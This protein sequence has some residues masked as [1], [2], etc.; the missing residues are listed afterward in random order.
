M[1]LYDCAMAPNPRRLRIFMA[2]KGLELPRIELNILA[3]ENLTPAFLAINPR[4]LLPTLELDDGTCIDEVM[5]ICRYLEELYPWQPLLGRTATERALVESLQRRAEFDGM[6]SGSEVFRNQHP[7]FAERSIPG[8]G[9]QPIPAIPG[10]V[11]RGHQTIGR[12][13]GWL[14]ERLQRTPY[15]VG[16][17]LSMADI[18][19]WCAVDFHQ[20][21]ERGIPADHHATHAWHSALKARPSAAA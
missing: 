16:D 4:G 3:G 13:Y 8:S 1:R 20:W 2:E 14:E 7:Q 17:A 21:I 19:A 11:Q 9:G 5:A 18:T 6:I 15:L 12:F 10:L